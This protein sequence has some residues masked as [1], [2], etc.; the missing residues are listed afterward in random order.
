MKKA[1]V[2]VIEDT[3]LTLSIILK[4]L[5]GMGY[6]TLGFLSCE[7]F[8]PKFPSL[9]ADIVLL[10]IELPGMS[11]LNALKKI[12]EKQQ[13]LP[14]II[15]T[16]HG[17]VERAVE[18]MKAG[19]YDFFTKP[20]DFTKLGVAVKNAVNQYILIREI[21]EIKT[22]YERSRMGNIIGASPPMQTLYQIIK[23]V[24]M[25][26]A[27]VFITGESGTGKELVALAI[28]GEGPRKNKPFIPLNCA[29]LPKDLMESELFGHEKGAFTGATARKIGCCELADGGTLLLDEICDMEYG[30]QAKLLRFLQQQ[31]FLRVGG[32]KFIEVNVRI[33]AATNKDPLEEIKSGGLR[34]DLYYRLNVVPIH[35]PPLRER[36]EDIPL[37]A[38][39]FLKSM[40]EKNN[41][42][43]SRFSPDAIKILVAC[44]WPGNVREL[45]NTIERVVV[46]NDGAEIT[47]KMLPGK[48]ARQEGTAEF[49]G[50]P[51][52]KEI[53]PLSIMEKDMI[54][55]AV[56]ICNGDLKEAAGRLGIGQATIYRKIKKYGLGK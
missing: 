10:D 9:G 3:A 6:D 45:E 26:K 7:D 15:I 39:S 12:K 54:R 22:K 48:M 43:F 40:S 24:S 36:R 29:A 16:G 23:N 55:K 25:S 18:A 20:I 11:G 31:K 8:F 50:V 49:S 19:A 46:L 14:V 17:T 34:E 13:A 5:G 30:L 52:K 38:M 53:I 33:I 27:T 21:S 41:K 42:K 56:D 2:V 32:E 4:K 37:L 28:H 44:R 51:A 1:K 35:V 47:E